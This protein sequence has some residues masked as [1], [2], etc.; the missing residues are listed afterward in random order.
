MTS[1]A[2]LFSRQQRWTGQ[3]AHD[4][5]PIPRPVGPLKMPGAELYGK[6]L[7]VNAARPMKHKLG[8]H[9]AGTRHRR[10]KYARKAM[11]VLF[12]PCVVV[13]V[14]VITCSW[15]FRTVGV[16]RHLFATHQFEPATT[17][18]TILVPQRPLHRSTVNDIPD[19][20]LDTYE[21]EGK[22]YETSGEPRTCG[23]MSECEVRGSEMNGI[24]CPLVVHHAM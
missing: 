19:M 23:Y 20:R 21:Q 18:P 9:T 3:I 14:Y 24:S 17:A 13:F 12:V 8:A 11:P 2:L 22:P 7:K 10:I 1:S 6:V 15:Q 16:M 5:C 4:S